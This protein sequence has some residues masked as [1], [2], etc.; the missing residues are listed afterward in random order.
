MI[1]S[2][3][4]LIGAN[5]TYRKSPWYTT[6]EDV[7]RMIDVANLLLKD[8]YN[9]DDDPIQVPIG[10]C[11]TKLKSI[12][13]LSQSSFFGE[14]QYPSLEEKATFLMYHIAKDHPNSNGNK[15]LSVTISIEF[16]LNNLAHLFLLDS[17]KVH[18]SMLTLIE[19][20]DLFHMVTSMV[21]SPS[22]MKDIQITLLKRFFLEIQTT[23]L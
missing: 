21:E 3:L 1:R 13:E 23:S 17:K 14:E 12:L 7:E 8:L 11:Y 15:R 20:K 16:C 18:D 9:G 22:E 2:R 10:Q 4:G 5:Y 19:N 6:M